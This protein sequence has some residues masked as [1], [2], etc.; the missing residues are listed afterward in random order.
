MLFPVTLWLAQRLAGLKF[1]GWR[2]P[3]SFS[4]VTI[5]KL[6]DGAPD[7]FREPR[8]RANRAIS[9]LPVIAILFS[10]CCEASGQMMSYG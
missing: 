1:R 5:R 10:A 6:C 8:G 7:G 2:F 3:L 4:K 9:P